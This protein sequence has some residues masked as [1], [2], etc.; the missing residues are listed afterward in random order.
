MRT[1]LLLLVLTSPACSLVAKSPA[2]Q[3]P[4]HERLAKADTTTIEDAAK[5]CFTREGWAPV[6]RGRADLISGG[7][8]P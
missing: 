3:S 7:Y 1:A 2:L 4:L 5:S 8:S 6:P